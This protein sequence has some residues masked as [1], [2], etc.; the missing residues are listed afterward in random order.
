MCVAEKKKSQMRAWKSR[1][2]DRE[3]KDVESEGAAGGLVREV[4]Q[5][6]SCH[7]AVAGLFGLFPH[8]GASLMW[9]QQVQKGVMSGLS[10]GFF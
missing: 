3:Q 1:E 9:T 2:T 8:A 7:A 5:L 4:I 6:Y 10:V